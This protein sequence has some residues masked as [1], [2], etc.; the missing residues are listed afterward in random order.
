[1]G[2]ADFVKGTNYYELLLASLNE[3]DLS[4]NDEVAFINGGFIEVTDMSS[5]KKI[6]IAVDDYSKI[7]TTNNS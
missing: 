2:I 4:I 1:M 7:Y 5:R 6:S 3:K